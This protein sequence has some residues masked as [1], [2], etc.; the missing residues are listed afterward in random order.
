M[1]TFE[2]QLDTYRRRADQ[3]FYWG[4]LLVLVGLALISACAAVVL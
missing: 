2:Q 3:A 4:G 1:K